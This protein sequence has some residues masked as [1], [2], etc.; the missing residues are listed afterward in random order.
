M[1]DRIRQMPKAEL[2]VHLD[3][4]LRPATMIDLAREAG[5]ALPANNAAELG[6]WMLV[7]D[8]RDLEDYLRRFEVTIALLQTPEA[9][10]R[11]AYEMVLDAH[12]DNLR[13][14]EV[15]YCPALSTRT[16]LA[17]DEVIAAEWRG[18]VRGME[19][20]GVVA[21]IINCSLRQFDPERSVEI[22]E[23]SLRMRS[24]G[25]VGFDLAGGEAGRPPER[26]REAF[27]I[28]ARGGLG[29]TVHAG[30]AAGWESI[31]EAI[32]ACHATR[33]GHGTRLIERPELLEYVRDRRILVEVNITSNVQTRAVP[34]AAD[35]PLRHYLDEGLA[36][37]LCTDSWLMSGVSLS[38]EFQLA[39]DALGCTAAEL[40]R[41]AL[42]GFEHA[43]LPWPMRSELLAR[44]TAQ[45]ESLS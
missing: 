7:S 2:H 44:A 1:R 20:T 19:E 32:H 15:R 28:A 29:I 25:V 26:H 11:V 38:D 40:D 39:Q 12:A 6:R 17:L 3:G 14:L 42:A 24:A 43:F 4:S 21:R 35:H 45:L 37:T 31:F 10:S 30:E 13:Y 16:G 41:M 18:L 23:H 5:I 8:A 33:I 36:V 34:T 22:A 27:E 9:I